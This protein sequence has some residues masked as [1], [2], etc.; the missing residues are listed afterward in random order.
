MVLYSLSHFLIRL[1]FGIWINHVIGKAV[2]IYGAD[3]GCSKKLAKQ[4]VTKKLAL[5]DEYKRRNHG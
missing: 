1:L 2:C 4:V 3:A 5:K